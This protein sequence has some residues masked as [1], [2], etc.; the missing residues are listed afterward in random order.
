MIDLTSELFAY[1][2]SQ[3]VLGRTRKV[4]PLRRV[5]LIYSLNMTLISCDISQRALPKGDPKP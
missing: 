3:R 5:Y 4:L 1:C 2:P